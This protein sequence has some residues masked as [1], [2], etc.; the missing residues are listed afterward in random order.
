MNP[1]TGKRFVYTGTIK[2]APQT[3][4]SGA[5]ILE[6]DILVIESTYADR[7]HPDRNELI[8]KFIED[9][10]TVVDDGGTALIPSFAVGR[11]QEIIAILYKNGLIN[12]T[13]I[14]GMAQH[15]TEITMRYPQSSKNEHLLLSAM[16][17]ANWVGADKSRGDTMSEPGIIVTTAGMLNGGPVLDYI[18]SLNAKSKIFITGYQVEGTNGRKLMDGKPILIDGRHY[19]VKTPFTYYD[20]SA[21]AGKKDLFDYVRKSKPETVLC[22]HGESSVARAFAESLKLE[23]FD[24]HA[25]RMGDSLRIDF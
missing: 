18:T 13:L 8:R 3:L 21:H 4:Q 24:A 9:V 6:S 19:D 22:V 7:D 5:E 14:D 11:A 2:V 15:A 17:T 12:I 20:F 16:K 23:G 10:R 1:K 25:P